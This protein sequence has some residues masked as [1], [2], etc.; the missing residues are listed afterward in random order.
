MIETAN[1][2]S[3]RLSL[4]DMNTIERIEV[5]K[6]GTSSIYGSGGTGVSLALL[7]SFR[8]SLRKIINDRRSHDK[9]VNEMTKSSIVFI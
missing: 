3:A 5:I 4:V 2:L 1:N 7:L 8:E 6:G 9:A